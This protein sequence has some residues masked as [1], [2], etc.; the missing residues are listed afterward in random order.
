MTH[1]YSRLYAMSHA[2]VSNVIKGIHA[3][4]HQQY[5]QEDNSAGGIHKGH[6]EKA[7]LD[8]LCALL[9]ENNKISNRIL[10]NEEL[11][12]KQGKTFHINFTLTAADTTS[13]L[14]RINFAKGPTHKAGSRNVPTNL[15]GDFP[16]SAAF[17]VE[18]KNRGPCVAVYSV[19]ET[20]F[21]STRA[22]GR[23]EPQETK[24]VDSIYPVY[25]SVNIAREVGTAGADTCDIEIT[26]E[27]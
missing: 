7:A 8:L 3:A 19:G 21:S 9:D 12:K 26:V 4:S 24:K 18:I 23:L 27:V 25:E 22:S 11:K 2:E 10:A 1:F 13:R 16:Y 5:F 20:G 6:H 15:T 17:S 14:A